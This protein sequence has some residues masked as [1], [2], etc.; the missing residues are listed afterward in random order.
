MTYF[1][2]KDPP[3]ESGSVTGRDDLEGV[4]HTRL[5]VWDL[6][7]DLDT[8]RKEVLGLSAQ[9]EDAKQCLPYVWRML[10][11]ISRLRDCRMLLAAAAVV[12]AALAFV[13]AVSLWCAFTL[14]FQIC[15]PVY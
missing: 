6:Y 2:K 14:Y 13:P 5:G 1:A 8:E 11:E 4:R 12:H 3:D 10:V 9:I 7:E 15:E